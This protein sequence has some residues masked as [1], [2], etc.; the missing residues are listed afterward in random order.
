MEALIDFLPGEVYGNR[1]RVKKRLQYVAL[2]FNCKLY[3]EKY[4][5][6]Y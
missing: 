1:K 2:G 3:F 5:I 4:L 6:N